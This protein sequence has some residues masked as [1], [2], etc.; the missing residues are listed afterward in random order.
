M[1]L[2]TRKIVKVFEFIFPIILRPNLILFFV[3]VALIISPTRLP[4]V[5]LLIGITC[6][7]IKEKLSR[8]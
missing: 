8:Q 3:S 4:L 2:V 6:R 1:I 7:K 5:L